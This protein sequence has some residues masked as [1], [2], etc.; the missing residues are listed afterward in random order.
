MT[1]M[2]EQNIVSDQ[3]NKSQESKPVGSATPHSRDPSNSTAGTPGLS[4]CL[5]IKK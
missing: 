4:R 5:R 2:V 1:E 3:A